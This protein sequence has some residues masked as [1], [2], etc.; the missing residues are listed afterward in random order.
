MGEGMVEEESSGGIGA[1]LGKNCCEE[2]AEE[3]GMG[4]SVEGTCRRTS[5]VHNI[6]G[7]RWQK[8]CELR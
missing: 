3:F 1:I 2:W 4:K 5:G 8:C 6:G 7:A